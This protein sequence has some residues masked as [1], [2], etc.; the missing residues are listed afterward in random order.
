[1]SKTTIPK[2]GITADAIDGTLI[3]DDAINSEHY[4][5]GS[6]D[7]A[8]VGDSQITAA[9]ATGLG[10]SMAD[11]WRVNTGAT[12]TSGNNNTDITANWERNDQDFAGIGTALSE[13]SGIFTFPVTV[14]YLVQAEFSFTN[15][16]GGTNRSINSCGLRIQFDSDHNTFTS[17]AEQR[18]GSNNTSAETEFNASCQAIIDVTDVSNQF[19][20]INVEH[21]NN[22]KFLGD[23]NLQKSGITVIRLGDT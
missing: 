23:T 22:M 13:S 9:K 21:V 17:R 7:T 5:D 20:K 18:T 8:H 10:I 12:F 15:R 16:E 14:I 2:G 3:A 19:F 11:Q 1:M 6:I 4:T